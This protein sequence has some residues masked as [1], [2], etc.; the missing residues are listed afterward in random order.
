MIN[1]INDTMFLSLKINAISNWL[2]VVILTESVFL[3]CILENFVHYIK[4]SINREKK[5]WIYP[6]SSDQMV[7][8]FNM[9]FIWLFC[10]SPWKSATFTSNYKQKN[11]KNPDF[12]IYS[13]LCAVA[14]ACPL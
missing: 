6:Y 2:R 10:G 5:M 7:N 9:V 4:I 14:E 13:L 12:Q 8:N 3:T 11:N 1:I